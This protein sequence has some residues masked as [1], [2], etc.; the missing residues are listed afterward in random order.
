MDPT[1]LPS[2]NLR[3]ATIRDIPRISAVATAGFFYSPAFTWERRYHAQYPE[4]TVKSYA[5][6]LAD[7]IRDPERI[8]LVVEDSYQPDENTK[9]GATIISTPN[10]KALQPGEKVIVGF[11][12]WSLPAGSKDIG[13]FMDHNDLESGNK[14]EF[15]GGLS[16][17]KFKSS[18]LSLVYAATV[19]AEEEY[20]IYILH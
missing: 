16:R 17:D 7:I 15:D 13:K 3:L 14:P 19:S 6:R 18:A 1:A 2:G 9:T 4:D 20:G 8:L 12:A 11:A 5:K 10:E